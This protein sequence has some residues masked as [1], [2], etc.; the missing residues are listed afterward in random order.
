M[1]FFA[2]SGCSPF[3]DLFGDL[4]HRQVPDSPA[5]APA[6]RGAI[7][8]AGGE[9]EICFCGLIASSQPPGV[10]GGLQLGKGAQGAG[11]AGFGFAAFG[12][13]ALYDLSPRQGGELGGGVVECRCAPVVLL[14]FQQGNPLRIFWGDAGEFF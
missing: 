10:A 5:G 14:R 3:N 6:P 13:D 4:V 9:A 2:Q 1:G 12:A 7:F 8:H 11:T